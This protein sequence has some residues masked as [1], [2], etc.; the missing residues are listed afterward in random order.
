[1]ATDCH[2][3]LWQLIK[4]VASKCGERTLWTL[5]ATCVSA[6]CIKTSTLALPVLHTCGWAPLGGICNTHKG[7]QRRSI[8]R[9]SGCRVCKVY[10]HENMKALATN[11]LTSAAIEST[12]RA[13][14]QR[15]TCNAATRRSSQRAARF[16]RM[17]IT[18]VEHKWCRNKHECRC[19]SVDKSD[20]RGKRLLE[21]LLLLL[22]LLLN[23]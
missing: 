8:G 1:M 7:K 17:Q 20:G 16:K 14:A 11:C 3:L 21:Q 2:R 23:P 13:N 6:G 18:I 10:S 5:G 15:A 9:S 19:K 12:A 22:P 4:K